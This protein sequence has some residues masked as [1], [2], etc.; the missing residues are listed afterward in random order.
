MGRCGKSSKS[1][2]S[3]G[4]SGSSGSS[5]IVLGEGCFGRETVMSRVETIGWRDD[6]S[7][8]EHT[9]KHLLHECMVLTCLCGQ[10]F[11]AKWTARCLQGFEDSLS[12][13]G[14]GCATSEEGCD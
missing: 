2:K 13:K 4:S 9:S 10:F 3:S 14:E 6:V 7:C 8:I 11:G 5:S 1:S 12:L